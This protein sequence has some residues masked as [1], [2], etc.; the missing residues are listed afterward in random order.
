[1]RIRRRRR[2]GL[3]HCL[4]DC[5]SQRAFRV[6]DQAPACWNC[7][8][9]AWPSVPPRAGKAMS[10]SKCPQAS[11]ASFPSKRLN[12]QPVSSEPASL[13]INTPAARTK[14]GLM[15][16]ITRWNRPAPGPRLTS[17]C[18]PIAARVQASC[19]MD[20]FT[21]TLMRSRAMVKCARANRHNQVPRPAPGGKWLRHGALRHITQCALTTPTT[22]PAP[23]VSTNRTS[24][25]ST[26]LPSG[27]RPRSLFHRISPLP[28]TELPALC[29]RR[30]ASVPW[31][32]PPACATVR[33]PAEPPASADSAGSSAAVR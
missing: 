4:R 33:A 11:G 29:V 27:T 15:G 1:M 14:S 31:L 10:R 3:S 13:T 8:A 21:T 6:Q 17:N 28:A 16:F 9:P 32:K 23:C 20:F 5:S 18:P 24:L 26:P 19:R 25:T 30:R 22:F 12:A 7:G 2:A